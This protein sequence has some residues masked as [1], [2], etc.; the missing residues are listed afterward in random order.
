M[1]DQLTA[2]APRMPSP[3]GD[4]ARV[5]PGRP[6]GTGSDL[7]RSAARQ[8]NGQEVFLGPALIGDPRNDEKILIHQLLRTP[9]R[10]WPATTAASTGHS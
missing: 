3:A 5:V 1:V 8:L 9:S 7:P 2:P 6:S 4:D 10:R